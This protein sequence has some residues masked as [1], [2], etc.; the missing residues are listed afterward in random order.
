M[1]ERNPRDMKLKALLGHFTIV[2]PPLCLKFEKTNAQGKMA[3]PKIEHFQLKNLR[4]TS[5][6]LMHYRIE[7]KNKLK[8]LSFSES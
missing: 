1:Q 7:T 8:K 5:F 2:D 4:V 6:D 3:H